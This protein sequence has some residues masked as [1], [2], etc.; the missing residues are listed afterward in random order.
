MQER[1]LPIEVDVREGH[2]R[3]W[4][5]K[6]LLLVWIQLDFGKQRAKERGTWARRGCT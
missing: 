4:P 2:R 1:R 3:E 5:V 6:D